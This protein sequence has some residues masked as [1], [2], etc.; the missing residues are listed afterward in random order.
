MANIR[1]FR[2]IV[3]NPEKI[4]DPAD[5]TAPPYDVISP[6]E[7]EDF[8]KRHPRNIIRL[9]LGKKSEQDTA[10]NSFFTRA[11]A[12]WKQWRE[13]KILIQD[14]E[15]ALYVTAISFDVE[16]RPVTRFGLIVTVGLEPFEKKIILPHERTFSKV[17]TER[18]ELMK[19]CHA[20]FCSIFSL[21]P[22]PENLILPM[23]RAAVT[24][25]A[26]DTD[27]TDTAG[28]R[29]KMWRITDK[30]VIETIAEQMRDKK[31]FIADG[32]HRYE[33]ALNFREW[34]KAND[35][36]FG[37][38]H[39][40][41]SVMMYLASMQ[42]PGMVILPAHRMLRAIDPE[43]MENFFSKAEKYFTV[44]TLPFSGEK[45][46]AE[47]PADFS[48]GLAAGA[49]AHTI[50]LFMK[51]RHQLFLLTLKPGVMIDL[52]S[53]EMP[54]AL[55]NL[56]VT[57]LTRLIFMEILGFDQERLDNHDL[58]GY[59]TSVSKAVD[60]VLSGEYDMS[61]ILN[62]TRIEQVREVA[63]LGLI[64]PRK[65]TYFYPKVITGQVMNSLRP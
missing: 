65:S 25:R 17:K 19:N 22:D 58:I 34:L 57:V 35:P 63:E 16:G 56:D 23:L 39:P 14:R 8:H 52:F 4:S 36:D 60:G 3:Y 10:E 55:L 43:T 29:Q 20:N 46:K 59:S 44:R 7:Q 28:H 32:H 45:G 38:D 33:T 41:N 50:G 53:Q 40:A 37:P 12:C 54:D 51:N 5:V 47:A 64:M 62:P 49:S 27:F 2:G 9:V 24:D 6:Q 18:L 21:Y 31:L 48:A 30:Q 26:P 13:E 61:F 42:D 11:A 15:P 1:P